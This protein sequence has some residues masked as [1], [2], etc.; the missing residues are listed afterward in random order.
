MKPARLI[1][2]LA[3]SALSLGCRGGQSKEEPLAIL[4]NMYQQ[5]RYNPQA[6]SAFFADGRTM[7]APVEGTVAREMELNPAVAEGRTADGQGFV[8][9]IP[10]VVIQRAGDME[11]LVERGQGRYGIYCVPCH[12][13]TGNGKGL[14]IQRAANQ[15][16]QPPTFHQ[17]RI[18]TMPDG[19]LYQVISYG[20]NNMPAYV[21][22]PA[23]DRWAIVA[24]VRALQLSQANSTGAAQ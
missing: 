3:L 17:D 6:Y 24:Y 11:K 10:A 1:A 4:R 5:P 13:G 19:Q 21:Q 15:A 16:F 14:V 12:D 23:D 9:T 8:D 20:Y 7:R 18:R 22:V 2:V